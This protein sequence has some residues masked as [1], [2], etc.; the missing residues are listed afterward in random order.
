MPRAKMLHIPLEYSD[1]ALETIESKGKA[2]VDE[3][4]RLIEL[5]GNLRQTVAPQKRAPQRKK[6][7]ARKEPPV[8]LPVAEA[9]L[10]RTTA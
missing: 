5:A 9:P 6:A 3:G 8:E 10:E 2:L 4:K 1:L 7:A